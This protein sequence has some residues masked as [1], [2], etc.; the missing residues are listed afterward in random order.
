MGIGRFVYTP[1]LPYMSEAL[2]LPASDAGLIASANFL[3]YLV[4]ALAASMGGL[5]GSQKHWFLGALACSALTTLGMGMTES[6][7]V[8]L[9]LRFAGGIAS[10]FA[11]VFSS[12]LVLERL[13]AMGRA[14]LSALLFAGVGSGIAGSALLIDVLAHGGTSWQSLWIASALATLLLLVVASVFIPEKA[15]RD[16][17]QAAHQSSSAI[18]AQASAGLLRL[19]LAYGLFGFGYVITATFISVIAK[20]D[21]ALDGFGEAVWLIVGLTA[22]PSI[23]LWNRVALRLG[24]AGAFSL[25]CLV[26]A[27]GVALSVS[28]GLAATAIGAAMLGATFMGITAL[29]LMEARRLTKGDPRR[30]LALMTAAFGVGQMLGPWLAGSLYDLTGGF[31]TATYTAAAALL[32]AAALGFRRNSPA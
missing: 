20:A 10:A 26:E 21:P 5:K 29:G 31:E 18:A 27:V 17:R 11:L 24:A 13:A 23:F 19:I 4:G 3:G 16:D 2:D 28:G 7:P 22:A 15:A 6:L 9:A 12:S 30:I 1:I 14:D 25:A 32:L 8:F